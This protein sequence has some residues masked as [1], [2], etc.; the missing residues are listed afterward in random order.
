MTHRNQRPYVS[1]SEAADLLGVSEDLV[2]EMVK[3]DT[4][5]HIVVGR[6]TIRIPRHELSPEAMLARKA[7]P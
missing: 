7:T 1:V 4:L 3:A 2:Y 6:R 5:P